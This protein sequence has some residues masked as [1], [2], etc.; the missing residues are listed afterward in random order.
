MSIE[1]TNKVAFK[2][3]TRKKDQHGVDKVH[4]NNSTHK[5]EPGFD[6]FYVR[7]SGFK[8]LIRKVTQFCYKILFVD[9]INR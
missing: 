4:K 2:R 9:D 1:L 8:P 7:N 5:K 3:Y 6:K